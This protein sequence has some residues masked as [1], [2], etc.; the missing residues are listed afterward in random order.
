MFFDGASNSVGIGV[1]AVLVSETCKYYSV[2]AMIRFYCTNNM[3]ECEACILELRIS[4]DMNIK[5]LF[6]DMRF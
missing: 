2:L 5:E 6:G 4:I 3:E 1:G